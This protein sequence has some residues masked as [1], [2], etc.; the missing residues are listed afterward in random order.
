MTVLTIAGAGNSGRPLKHTAW[1]RSIS[2]HHRATDWDL[3][4]D[5]AAA[6][7]QQKPAPTEPLSEAARL[8]K[9]PIRLRRVA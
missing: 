6:T 9:K 1:R 8:P 5:A 2:H 7:P 4:L 3:G